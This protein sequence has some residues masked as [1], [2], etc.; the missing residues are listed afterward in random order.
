LIGCQTLREFSF[1]EDSTESYI[2]TIDECSILDSSLMSLDNNNDQ[3]MSNE[4]FSNGLSELR[5]DI[6]NFYFQEL[7]SAH[8]N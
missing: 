4:I 2:E 1:N 7:Q 6:S 5:D 3:Q 8:V